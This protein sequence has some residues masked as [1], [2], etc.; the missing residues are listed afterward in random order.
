MNPGSS[1]FQVT[2]L[3]INTWQTVISFQVFLSNTNNFE[4]YLLDLLMEPQQ[5]LTL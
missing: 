1:S 3:N 2:I 4:T 5:V